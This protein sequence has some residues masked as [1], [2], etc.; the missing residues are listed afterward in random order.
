MTNLSLKELSNYLMNTVLHKVFYTSI[1]VVFL[2]CNGLERPEIANP[3]NFYCCR[4]AFLTILFQ[5]CLHEHTYTYDT[6][7]QNRELRCSEL[8][9]KGTVE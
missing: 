5:K 6:L 8:S 2:G 1:T 7:N 9:Y 3:L 4:W